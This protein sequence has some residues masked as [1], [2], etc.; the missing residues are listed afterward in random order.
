MLQLTGPTAAYLPRH[1]LTVVAA[2]CW[3]CHVGPPCGTDMTY[4]HFENRNSAAG[5][6][7]TWMALRGMNLVC[8]LVNALRNEP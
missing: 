5:R 6:C 7:M 4:L 1:F 3:N 8:V 2:G